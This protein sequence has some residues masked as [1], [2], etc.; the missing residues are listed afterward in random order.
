MFIFL[1]LF[2]IMALGEQT[3]TVIEINPTP[4]DS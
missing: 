2:M 1:N 3:D 4:V